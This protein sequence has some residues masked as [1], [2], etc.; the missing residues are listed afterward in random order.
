VP[1]AADVTV[2][3]KV[4]ICPKVDGFSEE[5]SDV[6]VACGI[7]SRTKFAVTF[8][9]PFITI[10]CGFVVPDKSPLKPVKRNPAFGTAVITTDAPG[11]K[12]PPVVIDPPDDGLA[13]AVS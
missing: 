4:T 11:L 1:A 13:D 12:K 6:L 5:V 2:A 3:V 9:G 7:T 10:V 8:F